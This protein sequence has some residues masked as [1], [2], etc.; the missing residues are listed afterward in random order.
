MNFDNQAPFIALWSL[1]TDSNINTYLALIF[2]FPWIVGIFLKRY[3]ALLALALLL[4]FSVWAFY[5]LDDDRKFPV[6]CLTQV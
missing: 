1:A 5:F 2:N 4:L 3:L 6:S